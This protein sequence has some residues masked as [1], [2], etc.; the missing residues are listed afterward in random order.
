MAEQLPYPAGAARSILLD[1]ALGPLSDNEDVEKVDFAPPGGDDCI[2]VNFG[3]EGGDVDPKTDT[4]L[5]FLMLQLKTIFH[6]SS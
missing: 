2:S 4:W 1:Q 5:R 3:G 6:F